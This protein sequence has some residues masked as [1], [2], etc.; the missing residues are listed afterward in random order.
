MME[1]IF[2]SSP[3]E[4]EDGIAKFG[5]HKSYWNLI[6][7]AELNEFL[8]QVE[9]LGWRKAILQSK[10]QK[11][12]ELYLFADAPVRADSSNYLNLDKESIVL[13]LGSGWGN[14]SFGLAP[15]V[16]N[17]VSADSSMESLRFIAARIRQ[18]NV[19]NIQ[20]VHID[21]LDFGKLPFKSGIFDAVFLNGVLEWVGSYLKNGDPLKIQENCLKEIKRVLKKDGQVFIGI[22]NRFGIKYFFGDPD[23]H[24]KYYKSEGLKFTTLVPRIIANLMSKKA[25]GIPYRTY[26]HSLNGYRSLLKRAG[27]SKCTFYWPDP[28]YRTISPTI[29]PLE[30]NETAQQLKKKYI[31]KHRMLKFIPNWLAKYFCNTYLIVAQN[32]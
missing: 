13:D 14:Y 7:E 29:Y 9:S 8:A 18:D 22:E 15:K 30:L 27:F 17:I 20:P 19:N 11:I 4:I 2:I 16:K 25:L 21:P 1:E 28:D 6:P 12:R 3:Q 24:T 10:V 26:T 31:Q 5:T 23:D 32:D